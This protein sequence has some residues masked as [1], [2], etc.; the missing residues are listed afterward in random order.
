MGGTDQHP[1]VDRRVGSQRKRLPARLSRF[2]V[3][4]CNTCFILILSFGPQEGPSIGVP[5]ENFCTLAAFFS[6]S[7]LALATG[8]YL[9]LRKPTMDARISG[10]VGNTNNR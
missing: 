5:V 2:A 10:G 6:V 1:L 9:K 8:L 3:S 7:G 4:K